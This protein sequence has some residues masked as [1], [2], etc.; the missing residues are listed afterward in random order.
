[1]GDWL[2]GDEWET[3]AS[4]DFA[5]EPFTEPFTI[6]IGDPDKTINME[7]LPEDIQQK[8]RKMG[9]ENDSIPF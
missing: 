1:M 8:L 4:E 3:A 2:L 7:K 5:V 9:Y 6:T